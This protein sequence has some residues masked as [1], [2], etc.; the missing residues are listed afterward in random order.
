[1]EGHCK[2]HDLETGEVLLTQAEGVRE[3]YVAAVNRW[4]DELEVCCRNRAVDRVELTT[5]EPLDQALL[6]YLVR[7]AKCF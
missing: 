6:D 1:M 5:D 3:G 7:R 4:R 2:F